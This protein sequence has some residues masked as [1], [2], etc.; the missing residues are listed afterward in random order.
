MKWRRIC[1]LPE[2]TRFGPLGAGAGSR[3]RVVMTV[4][5]Y[6]AI[7]LI[8]QQ[9]FNQEECA[10]HMNIARTTV[11]GIYFRAR[12]KVADSLVNGKMLIIEGG[13]YRLC[14]GVDEC[15]PG[16]QR[17]GRGRRMRG[18]RGRRD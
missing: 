10:A 18:N 7:R 1:E 11:Q 6:E 14:D 3:D 9:G 4:D 12:K 15:G 5:E 13:E 2:V 16:C 17:K 8:D